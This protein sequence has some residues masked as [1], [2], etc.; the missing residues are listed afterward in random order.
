MPIYLGNTEQVLLRGMVCSSC[1]NFFGRKIEPTLIKDPV[2]QTMCAMF[3]VVNSRTGKVIQP[4]LFDRHAIPI[5]IPRLTPQLHLAVRQKTPV[6]PSAFELTVV[7]QEAGIR[8]VHRQEYK[9]K[10]VALFSRAI[11]K[12]AFESLVHYQMTS[13]PK[14][15]GLDLFTELFDPIREWV[16]YGQPQEKVRPLARMVATPITREW[17]PLFR[18]FDQHL[19]VELR[20]Y[21]DWFYVSLTSPPDQV[22]GHLRH[23]YSGNV[24]RICLIADSYGPLSPGSGEPA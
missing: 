22:Q 10:D 9:R 16:R 8:D 20:L 2:I 6:R 21:A 19:A 4:R 15:P 23:W 18:R 7:C 12:V 3:H 24:E 13:E 5:D 17:Q 14:I 1:N 11:H